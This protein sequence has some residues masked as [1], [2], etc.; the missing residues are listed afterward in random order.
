[1]KSKVDILAGLVVCKSLRDYAVLNLSR[2]D[3]P[4]IVCRRFLHCEARFCHVK[5]NVLA[6]VLPGTDDNITG[7]DVV[8]EFVVVKLTFCIKFTN[9]NE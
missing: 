7:L 2:L 6:I 1:M 8:G 5:V 4:H 9:V 3:T